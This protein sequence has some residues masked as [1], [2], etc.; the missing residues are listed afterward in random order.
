MGI[1]PR[2]APAHVEVT[3]WPKGS[4]VQ[5]GSPNGDHMVH[6]SGEVH[7]YLGLELALQA[8][9]RLSPI[10]RA[11]LEAYYA[12]K[13]RRDQRGLK[14]A[15]KTAWDALHALTEAGNEP[16]PQGAE[17][18]SWEARRARQA[19]ELYTHTCRVWNLVTNATA[20]AEPADL[21]AWLNGEDDEADD[22]PS[23]VYRIDAA[24]YL[25]LTAGG[26]E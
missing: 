14:H 16:D 20:G 25:R 9:A 26:A 7:W 17:K 12:P 24:E 10:A 19:Q 23:G 11:A 1:V 13:E 6:L 18:R 15:Q 4:S 8:M 22:I 2:R 21:D 3:C 5:Q